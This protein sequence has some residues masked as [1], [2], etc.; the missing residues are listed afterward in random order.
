M[1]KVNAQRV[2]Y[3]EEKYAEKRERQREQQM[4]KEEMVL[5]KEERLSKLRESVQQQLDHDK[6]LKT[7]GVDKVTVCVKNRVSND[8]SAMYHEGVVDMFPDHG[9]SDSKLFADPKFELMNRLVANNLHKSKYAKEV[10]MKTGDASRT[11]R[12]CSHSAI[13]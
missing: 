13:F 10:L 1:A 4:E 11:R 6:I 2:E 9:Y 3:R 7:S 8:E 12:D 5:M